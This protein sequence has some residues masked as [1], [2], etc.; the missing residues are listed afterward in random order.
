MPDPVGSIYYEYFHTGK[1]PAD[2]ACTYHVE[3]VGEDHLAKA[4]D[5]TVVD[6]VVRFTDADAFATA[7]LLAREEGIMGGGST[8]A[9]VWA[10]LRLA[11]RLEGEAM[12]V[13]MA[14]DSGVKY[15]SKCYN[16]KWMREHE[17]LE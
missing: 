4:M 13:T 6:D 11:E 9:N 7:R 2:G 3:G 1:V 8:G 15:L 12:I 10:A 17:F 16:D 14:P 5:F